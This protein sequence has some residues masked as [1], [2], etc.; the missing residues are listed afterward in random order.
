MSENKKKLS[1]ATKNAII[2][3]HEHGSMN[4]HSSQIIEALSTG[5]TW[6]ASDMPSMKKIEEEKRQTKQQLPKTVTAKR[7]ITPLYL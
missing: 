7:D 6:T 5:L 3:Y 4:Q 2:T 1:V